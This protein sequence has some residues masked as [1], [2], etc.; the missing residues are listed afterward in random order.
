MIYDEDTGERICYIVAVWIPKPTKEDDYAGDE[1]YV[2][3]KGHLEFYER[4]AKVFDS[5][6]EAEEAASHALWLHPGCVTEIRRL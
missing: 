2:D 1:Y 3:K 5:E 4:D 6:E